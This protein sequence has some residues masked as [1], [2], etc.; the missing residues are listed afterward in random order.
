MFSSELLSQRRKAAVSA[1]FFEC[2]IFAIVATWNNYFLPLIMLSDP[3]WYPLTVGL[4]QWSSQASGVA[5][6]SIGRGTSVC[7][8]PARARGPRVHSAT[9]GFVTQSLPAL[10][11][12]QAVAG[13]VVDIAAIKHSP[14]SGQASRCRQRMGCDRM[15][16]PSCLLALSV[17]FPS[18]LRCE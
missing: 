15:A 9:C 11:L 17:E 12:R 8:V 14:A 2:L 6:E 13:V 18:A 5:A 1:G 10:D 3:A 7:Q 16:P 4:N